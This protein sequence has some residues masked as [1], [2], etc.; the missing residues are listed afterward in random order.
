MQIF[1]KIFIASSLCFV[2][3]LQLQTMNAQNNDVKMTNPLLQKSTLQYQ[4]PI[5]V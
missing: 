1:S 4:A 2:L 5:L 3:S